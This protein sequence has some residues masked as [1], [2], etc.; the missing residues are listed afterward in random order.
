MFDS[1][2][3]GFYKSEQQE[4]SI[5]RRSF[6][7]HALQ[8]RAPLL[9]VGAVYHHEFQSTRP[10]WGATQSVRRKRSIRKNFN[11]RAPCGARPVRFKTGLVMDVFQSTRPVWGAT[12]TKDMSDPRYQFQSTRPVWGA[13][14]CCVL[15]CGMDGLFQSTRPVWGATDGESYGRSF[16]DISIHAPRVGRDMPFPVSL[17]GFM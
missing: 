13:T 12:M 11:P 5:M 14:G 4:S 15:A 3:Q 16:V 1:D 9:H 2:T 17:I 10:V 8:R 6:N 7:P